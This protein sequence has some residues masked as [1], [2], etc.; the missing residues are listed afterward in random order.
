MNSDSQPRVV[1]SWALL[2]YTA[3]DGVV[4]LGQSIWHRLT[5]DGCGALQ[6]VTWVTLESDD[7]ACRE[8]RTNPSPISGL[9]DGAAL[10]VT[11]AW[12]G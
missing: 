11:G 10:R 2:T 4:P 7:G 8:L 12:N 5:A 9:R 6:Q 1:I 3:W